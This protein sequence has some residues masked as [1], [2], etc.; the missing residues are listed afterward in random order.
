MIRTFRKKKSEDVLLSM[1]GPFRR[2]WS[3]CKPIF[4]NSW[5]ITK[6][7]KPEFFTSKWPTAALRWSWELRLQIPVDLLDYFFFGNFYEKIFSNFWENPF[8]KLK[9]IS[10]TSEEIIS[11]QSEA[12][13][14]I[15]ILFFDRR[16]RPEI[17]VKSLRGCE[18]W[19]LQKI[20]HRS[21]DRKKIST[22]FFH[23][24]K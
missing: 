16:F 11:R 17:H 13:L 7:W 8:W 22:S 6:I 12:K 18:K 14:E 15:M 2:F 10:W 20:L 1:S 24:K 23:R 21:S 9:N 4:S 5:P 19:I 3:L